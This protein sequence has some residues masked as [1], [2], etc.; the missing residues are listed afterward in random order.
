[1]PLTAYQRVQRLLL[2]PV[3]ETAFI[4]AVLGSDMGTIKRGLAEGKDV[5]G[6]YPAPSTFTRQSRRNAI[7]RLIGKRPDTPERQADKELLRQ[8]NDMRVTPLVCV[9][10]PMP[11]LNKRQTAKRVSVFKFLI[12]NGA[13]INQRT[14]N[15]SAA[16]L[17]LESKDIDELTK[18]SAKDKGAKDIFELLDWNKKLEGFLPAEILMKNRFAS[19]EKIRD[20]VDRTE[21]KD[22]LL[23]PAIKNHDEETVQYILDKG[24]DVNKP[25]ESGK[26]PLDA[27]LELDFDA[28]SMTSRLV[29]TKNLDTSYKSTGDIQNT[30]CKGFLLSSGD[31]FK[32]MNEI[33]VPVDANDPDLKKNVQKTFK[34]SIPSSEMVRGLKKAGFDFNQKDEEETPLLTLA[35]QNW[36]I[37]RT[38]YEELLGTNVDLNATDARQKT[39]RDYADGFKAMLLD[40]AIA[41]VGQTA[42]S[43]I[44]SQ[45][46]LMPRP[47]NS[48]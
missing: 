23:V 39:A 32:I 28:V 35:T 26:R 21:D 48:R 12:R 34:E 44:T 29:G 46:G 3:T 27:A 19:K 30:I 33:N 8:E 31:S 37:G 15:K 1:M 20:A 36:G 43:K 5:N 7:S 41:E 40:R 45:S 10:E 42:P 47:E 17:L 25:D 6:F 38:A 2:G 24:A 22:A 9:L 16:K 13:D 14:K 18:K 4:D 11:S